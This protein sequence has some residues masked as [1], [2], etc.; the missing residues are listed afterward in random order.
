[1][2]EH[3]DTCDGPMNGLTEGES[4]AARGEQDSVPVE[5]YEEA[6]ADGADEHLSDD[7][8][9]E[10]TEA[11][12]GERRLRITPLAV[13]GFAFVVAIGCLIAWLGY[14]KYQTLQA[15]AQRNEFVEAARQGALN[16]TTIDYATIDDDV[17]RILDSSIGTLHEDFEQRS[18]P[19]IDVVKKAR[20]T[21]QGTITAAGLESQDG[22]Q[23]QVL[24]AVLVKTSSATGP[25]S[26]PRGWRMRIGVQKVGDFAKVSNVQFVP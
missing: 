24:V 9:D 13:A 10:A 26:Q 18:Q 19:F 6:L 23:A 11:G 14:L 4:E 5:D 15:Q 3:A 2:A 21:S 7:N 8:V 16:L 1:M 12:S 25:E 22:D 17:R 20:S